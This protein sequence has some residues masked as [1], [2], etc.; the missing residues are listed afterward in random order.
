MDRITGNWRRTQ[1]GQ[2]PTRPAVF[3]DSIARRDLRDMGQQQG[4]GSVPHV[5]APD[6]RRR[7]ARY[8]QRS[9]DAADPGRRDNRLGSNTA[10]PGLTGQ[11]QRLRPAVMA[12]SSRRFGGRWA[13]RFLGNRRRRLRARRGRRIDCCSAAFRSMMG[14]GGHQQSFRRFVRALAA[15]G[16][17]NQS[18]W[19]LT[20]R[21]SDLARDAGINEINS[22]FGGS[23]GQRAVDDGQYGSRAGLFRPGLDR[24]HRIHDSRDRLR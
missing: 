9:G 8:E 21:A 4:S 5:R 18:R 14:G 10:Q 20:N 15:G 7:P 12:D 11:P 16:P 17:A 23:S 22:F 1:T 3:L 6:N 13:A 24:R 2:A 19:E